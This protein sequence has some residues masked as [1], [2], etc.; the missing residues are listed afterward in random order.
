MDALKNFLTTMTHTLQQQVA[1][2]VKKTME[3]ASSMRALPAFDYKPTRGCEPFSRRDHAGLQRE[4]DGL[5]DTSRPSANE[6]P[7]KERRDHHPMLKKPQPMTADLESHSVQKYCQFYEQKGDT[8]VECKELKKALHELT[9]KGQIYHFLERG[10]RFFHEDLVR[11]REEPRKEEC[12]TEIVATITRGCAE[13][14]SRDRWKHSYKEPSNS[15]HNESSADIIIWGCLRK[16]KYPIRDITT[17]LHPILGFGGQEV[18]SVGMFCPPCGSRTRLSP[19][20]S[21]SKP[22]SPPTSYKFN[23]WSI[24]AASENFWRSTNGPRMLLDQHQIMVEWPDI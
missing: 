18:A 2:Q 21:K 3:A 14:I 11:A 5:H 4:G 7:H 16:H 8:T 6:R 15:P 22:L 23:M 10:K 17:L 13:G 12:S 1:K 19:E 9:D 20:T 24:T